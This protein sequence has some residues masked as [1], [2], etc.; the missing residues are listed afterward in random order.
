VTGSGEEDPT[1]KGIRA[2]GHRIAALPL[3][4][5]ELTLCRAVRARHL[6]RIPPEPLYHRG[7]AAFGARYTPLGGPAGLYLASDQP[8]AYAE[9]QDLLCDARGR[10]LPLKPRDPVVTVYVKA[11]LGGVLDLTRAG[12]RR[13]LRVTRSAICSEWRPEMER[14]LQGNAAMPVTQQIGCAA[15]ATRRVRGILFPSARWTGGSCL[16]V[17][18]DRLVAAEGDRVE[19]VD[20]A[21][22]YTQ[23]LP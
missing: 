7:S 23:R 16:V 12:T 19:A 21:G 8:T 3:L 5:V 4:R 2:L 9:I 20:T 14:W 17:F 10:P 18:P 15:H 6:A 22:T 11:R 13:A 1:G